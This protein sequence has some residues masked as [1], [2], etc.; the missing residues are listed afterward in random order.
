MHA[1]AF[2]FGLL[3]RGQEMHI[4]EE[5]APVRFEAVPRAQGVQETD[6][7]L[8]EYVP[9]VQGVHTNPLELT[10]VPAGHA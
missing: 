4:E 2:T 8:S 10:A 1:V 3:P 6:P 9:A 5:F 7:S